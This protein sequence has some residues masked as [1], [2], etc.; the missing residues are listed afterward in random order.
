MHPRVAGRSSRP[1]VAVWLAG[2]IGLD[3]YASMA[4]RLAWEVSE[5]D[6]RPPTL[7]I[8][9]LAPSITIGRLGSRADV[10]VG[11]DELRSRGLEVRFVGRGGG[12]V[13]HG[14]GQIGVGLFASLADLG[15]G[16]HAVGS[17]VERL[18]AGLEGAIRGLRCGAARDS[19]MH[20]IFGRTGL[21]AAVGV[22]VRRG[23]VW[24]GG[25]LNIHPPLELHRRIR[26]VPVAAGAGTHTMGSVEADV[27]RRVRLQD[28]RAALVE[29][30]V[31]AFEFPRSHIQSGFPFP[32]QETGSASA[33]RRKSVG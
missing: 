2:T 20:G 14:P 24:H 21:L 9:D 19:R 1:P 26:S 7:V 28:A 31:D 33:D 4:E 27:Q 15:L 32:I 8:H 17:Y 18:E 13:L 3:A 5:P 23:V 11:D 6:G 22:A 30:L 29:H 25:F 12:A 16:R 10:A